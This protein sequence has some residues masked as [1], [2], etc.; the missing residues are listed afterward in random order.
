MSSL[1]NC[2]SLLRR[3][4]TFYLVDANYSTDLR[5][6][7]NYNIFFFKMKGKRK[8]LHPVLKSASGRIFFKFY[9]SVK[10]WH[11]KDSDN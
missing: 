6:A 9:E 2:F 10:I 7:N 3:A 11:N 8:Q 1:S 5:A 4:Q